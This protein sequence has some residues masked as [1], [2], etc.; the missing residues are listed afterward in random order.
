MTEEPPTAPRA[1]RVSLCTGPD[2]RCFQVACQRSADFAITNDRQE[3]ACLSPWFWCAK[4]YPIVHE[5]LK[6]RGHTVSL[7]EEAAAALASSGG[8]RS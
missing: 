4:D 7:T 2:Q 5:I 1:Y 8:G 6:S 3:A